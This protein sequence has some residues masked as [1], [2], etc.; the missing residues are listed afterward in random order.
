M[1]SEVYLQS[2]EGVQPP[3]EIPASALSEDALLG[4]IDSFIQREGTDYG[5]AEVSYATKVK[6]VRS[7]ID[8]GS[9]KIVFD[10]NLQSVS[11]MTDV[12]WK[13]LNR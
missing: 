2:E 9:V 11:L 10:P 7:Q 5:V 8:K 3:L 1:E 13:K 12:D 4:V 6:Q